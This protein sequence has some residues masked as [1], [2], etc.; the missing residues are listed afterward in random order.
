LRQTHGGPAARQPGSPPAPQLPASAPPSAPAPPAKG[1]R[2][3]LIVGAGCLTI[4]VA[5][6]ALV[7]LVLL[8]TGGGVD[9]AK[10]QL[11]LLVSGDVG[12]AYQKTSPAFRKE[13]TLDDYTAL[14]NSRPLIRQTKSISIPERQ[15]EN[16]ITTITAQ[17]TDAA[18]VVRGVPMRIRKEGG[19]WLVIAI[20]LAAFPAQVATPPPAE[21]EATPPPEGLKPAAPGNNGR[22]VGTVVI[23]SGRTESGALIKPGEVVSSAIETLSADIALINHPL[24]GAVQ[25]WIEHIAS[26]RK[27]APISATI[28]GE[29][30]GNLP[31]DLHMNEEKLTPGKYRLV[32]VLDEDMRFV[33]EFEVK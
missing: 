19:E 23:G 28:E 27:T 6:A 29:G 13:I 14:V 15:V 9:A 10:E 25:V 7:F 26:G 2:F 30:S 12:T 17:L 21:P 24:G 3:G 20:D 18:G 32:I 8:L 1:R 11:N 4:I 33:R 16:D 5:I 31:F 22:G